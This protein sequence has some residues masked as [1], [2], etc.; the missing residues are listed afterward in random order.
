MIKEMML[1]RR[2]EKPLRL[3]GNATVFDPIVNT[4]QKLSESKNEHLIKILANLNKAM[5]EVQ[6]QLVRHPLKDSAAAKALIAR[7]E[8]LSAETGIVSDFDQVLSRNI[9]LTF[10]HRLIDETTLREKSEKELADVKWE[11]ESI[12]S[13]TDVETKQLNV[14]KTELASTSHTNKGLETKLESISQANKDT[15]KDLEKNHMVD[16]L[17][18]KVR[19]ATAEAEVITERASLDDGVDAKKCARRVRKN[20]E[21]KIKELKGELETAKSKASNAEKERAK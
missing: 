8:N 21:R 18:L 10:A 1:I 7:V 12:K 2:I 4:Q 13:N 5:I 14:L 15:L 16:I 9:E 3:E 6:E 11:L 19:L 20:A 17:A